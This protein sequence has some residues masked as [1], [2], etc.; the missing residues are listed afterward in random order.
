MVMDATENIRRALAHEINLKPLERKDL[1]ARWGKVW[2][3]LELGADFEVRGF[4]TPFV[5]VRRK[6]DYKL[7]SLVLQHSPR[8]YFGWEEDKED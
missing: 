2:D 3:T 4:L 8:F 5:V 6:S 7:G 1:E